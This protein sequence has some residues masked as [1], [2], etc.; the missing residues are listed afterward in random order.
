MWPSAL[1]PC[2]GV[3][4]AQPPC[5]GWNKT[6]CCIREDGTDLRERGT[7]APDWHSF[8]TVGTVPGH[9]RRTLRREIVSIAKMGICETV[10]ISVIGRRD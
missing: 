5:E 2:A 8:G 3:A 9:V 6:T 10:P 7:R 1:P 4:P